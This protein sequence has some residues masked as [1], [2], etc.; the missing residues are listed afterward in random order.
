ME[1]GGM[2]F[3]DGEA[4]FHSGRENLIQSPLPLG[5]AII[6]GR[7]GTPFG[8]K[9]KNLPGGNH[10][11][12]RAVRFPEIA[13]MQGLA[14]AADDAEGF[15]ALIDT[16]GTKVAFLHPVVSAAEPQGFKGAGGDAALAAVALFRF[17]HH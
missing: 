13:E 12:Y 5:W 4:G 11:G 1:M 2:M 3:V 10:L 15:Q 17:E 6:Y 14:L 9:P 7:T 8:V 16:V